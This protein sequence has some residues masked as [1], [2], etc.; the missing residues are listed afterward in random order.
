MIKMIR[1]YRLLT[2]AC[3]AWAMPARAQ[4]PHAL[5]LPAVLEAARRDAPSVRAA[6]MHREAARAL[7][8]SEATPE[9]PLLEL[10][11][12]RG[13]VGGGPLSGP[14][15]TWSVSQQI[16]FPTTL[17]YRGR[18]A[19]F[20]ADVASAMS[21]RA[22]VEAS[23][24]AREAYADLYKAER[25]VALL[26]EI[27][28]LL[29]RFSRVAE[30]KFAAGRG[31]QADALKA[32][33][34]LTRMLNEKALA[35][36]AVVGARAMLNAAMGRDVDGPLPGLAPPASPVPSASWTE[37]R[38]LALAENP[39]LAAAAGEAD[40]ARAEVGMQRSQWLPDVSL[41]YRRREERGVRSHDASLGLSLPLWF[42]KQAGEI[43]H[44][45]YEARFAQALSE[46][47]K[48]DVLAALRGAH[49]WVLT[50]S[51]LREVYRTTMIPQAESALRSA[52]AA[53]Q[54]DRAS[55]LD[56][57][58]AGRSLMTVRLEAVAHEADFERALAALSR[59]VGRETVP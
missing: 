59:A 19:S 35:S 1:L 32:Q 28:E 2:I 6:A 22:V 12:A 4:A 30:A 49:A 54:A 57:L 17:L 41:R 10:E 11:R 15:K 26:D 50:E 16:P 38:A 51:L 56:L 52:E 55:F 58:D 24:R 20:A 3:L 47:E 13:P 53:Y 25:S 7:V 18:T 37:L 31:T 5:T 46:A 29:R 44:A 9:K 33:L 23:A 8:K 36:A 34:E 27:V 45:A 43:S 21:R 42:W 48:L 40:K 39:G 14:E